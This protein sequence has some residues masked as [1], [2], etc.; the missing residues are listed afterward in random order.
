MGWERGHGKIGGMGRSGAWGDLLVLEDRG[1]WEY[2]GGHGMIGGHRKIGGM[3][4]SGSMVRWGTLEYQGTLEER[5]E[6]VKWREW[7]VYRPH[8]KE[9][10][11]SC[12]PILYATLL[13]TWREQGG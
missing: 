10:T 9:N 11:K 4:T 13:L 7:D 12:S 3:G 8:W 2:F 6:G 5:G 1:T